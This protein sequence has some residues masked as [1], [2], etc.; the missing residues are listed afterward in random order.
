MKRALRKTV[1]YGICVV[2][3]ANIAGCGNA[4]SEQSGT[5]SEQESVETLAE[6]VDNDA[7]EAGGDGVTYRVNISLEGLD[8]SQRISDTLFGLF[9]EDINYAVDGGMYVE[10]IKNRSFE[11]GIEARDEQLHGWESTNEAVTFSVHDGSE[12]GR[13]LTRITRSTWWC[14]IQ[15]SLPQVRRKE[16]AMED[17]WR[18]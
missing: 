11:Y 17:I 14:K 18:A 10:M 12:D 3:A 7:N 2:L 9:L 4:A 8:E 6:G 13:R 5:L 15:G 16:S 1:T